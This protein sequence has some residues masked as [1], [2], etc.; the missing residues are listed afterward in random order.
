MLAARIGENGYF[1]L[2]VS[3]RHALFVRGLPNIHSDPFDRLLIAQAISETLN[4]LTA[5]KRLPQYSP[6]VIRHA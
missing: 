5:D 1:D 6:L 2:P 4:L 3:V